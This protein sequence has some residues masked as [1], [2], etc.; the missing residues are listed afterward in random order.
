MSKYTS[1]KEA[2]VTLLLLLFVVSAV[3]SLALVEKVMMLGKQHIYSEV[4]PWAML[5]AAILLNL[6]LT[7]WLPKSEGLLLRLGINLI[8]ATFVW[9]IALL[10][11]QELASMSSLVQFP[12]EEVGFAGYC[13]ITGVACGIGFLLGQWLDD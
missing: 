11:S 10:G 8:L 5:L 6:A 9:G 3:T 4:A 13:S 12:P 1:T 7:A 2:V